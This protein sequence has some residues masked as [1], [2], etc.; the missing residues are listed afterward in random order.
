MRL[1]KSGSTVREFAL[2]YRRPACTAVYMNAVYTTANPTLTAI[3]PMINATI[4]TPPLP[5]SCDLSTP[6]L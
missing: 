2:A 1:P 5:V 6:A 3:T 4:I